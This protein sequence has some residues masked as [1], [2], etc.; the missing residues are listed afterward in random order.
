MHLY[1]YNIVELICAGL[2]IGFFANLR[3][4]GLVG[5]APFLLFISGAEVLAVWQ[6]DI[7]RVSTYGT[8]YAIAIA[9]L[10]F[11]GY[12][13]MHATREI[14]MKRIIQ[15]GI[16]VIFI[17]TLIACF[18]FPQRYLAFYY[19]IIMEGFFLTVCALGY[20]YFQ[21][22]EDQLENPAYDPVGWIAIG[23]IIFFS[24]IC[25]V[26]SLY[27]F[28]RMQQLII[29]GEQ[30]YILIPRMLSILLYSCISMAIITCKK[31]TTS[32]SAS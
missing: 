12:L 11:Y 7:A 23:V 26:F 29:F 25:I 1:F 10:F 24:G 20:L 9:E 32:S 30:I 5:L 18:F 4:Q 14:Y 2:A 22:D 13:F 16:P 6:K 8:N 15:I 27:E 19:C 21:F 28:I 3:N 17:A 31:N